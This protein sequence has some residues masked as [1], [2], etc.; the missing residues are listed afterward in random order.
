MRRF[1]VPTVSGAFPAVISCRARSRR[2]T[3]RFRLIW[4]LVLSPFR[5]D[6]TPSP[7]P[8]LSLLPEA[9]VGDGRTG[10][11]RVRMI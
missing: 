2:S 1:P 5:C 6:M 3:A 4:N 11:W 8:T 9:S 10:L 7:D